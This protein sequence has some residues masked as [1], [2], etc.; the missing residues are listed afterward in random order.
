MEHY[1]TIK[2]NEI[3]PFAATW[4]DLEIIILSQVRRERQIQCHI[5]YMWNL[6][7]DKNEHIY[8]TE[9]DSQT[10]RYRYRYLQTCGCQ[11]QGRREGLGTGVSRHRL[12][13]VGW[14]NNKILLYST[15]N[16]IQY[17]V[18]NRN[19]KEYEKE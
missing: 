17:P 15:G 10:Q 8:N 4:M 6:E 19:G 13:Y 3:L 16:C 14:M 5:T 18:I 9:T 7:H 11:G 1:S 2:K 12:L